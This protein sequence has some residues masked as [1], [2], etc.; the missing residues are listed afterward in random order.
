MKKI[1]VLVAMLAMM[2][3]AAAPAFAQNAEGANFEDAE[4]SGTATGGDVTAEDSNVA[5]CQNIVQQTIVNANTAAVSQNAN[6]TGGVI[7]IDGDGGAGG[8][9][10]DDGGG[11]AGT[12]SDGDVEITVGDVTAENMVELGGVSA[13][14]AQE[15]EATLNQAV[16][17]GGK[18]EAK[19][20]EEKKAE[21]KAE[22][23]KTGGGAS[24]FALGAGALLVGGGLLARRIIK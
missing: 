11:G 2:M 23:P 4:I 18:A 6:A 9:D 15:C 8:G 21:G 7:T 13:D 3:V 12:D 22:L 14:V 16:A 10:D 24:L 19:A 1:T 20:G 5:F 17:V